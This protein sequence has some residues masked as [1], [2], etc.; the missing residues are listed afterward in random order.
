MAHARMRQIVNNQSFNYR[1]DKGTLL[2]SAWS[3]FLMIYR[4][5]VMKLTLEHGHPWISLLT[6]AAKVL[7]RDAT[8]LQCQFLLIN[9]ISHVATAVDHEVSQ[10]SYVAR[11]SRLAKWQQTHV[12]IEM[13]H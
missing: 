11:S 12:A 8:D 7:F 1:I 4:E 3:I 13:Y 2:L 5:K 10:G 6:C 9:V